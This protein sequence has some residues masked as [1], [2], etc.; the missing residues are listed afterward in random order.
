MIANVFGST[1]NEVHFGCKSLTHG[2]EELL[3]NQYGRNILIEH[4]LHKYLSINFREI[5]KPK[6]Y[7]DSEN[8]FAYFKDKLLGR[9]PSPL[10]ASNRLEITI[11]NWERSL[12]TVI[13]DN[14]LRKKILVSDL[15][16]I[17]V[18]G[19]IHDKNIH[20]VYLLALS[21]VIRDLGKE[22][23]W[24]NVTMQGENP[25]ILKKAI[26]DLKLPTRERFTF[27]YLQTQGLNAVNSFDTAVLAPFK[28]SSNQE[29]KESGKVLITGGVKGGVNLNTLIL[30]VK[31]LGKTPVYLPA[32]ISDI[33]NIEEM[34]DAGVEMIPLASIHYLDLP[35][36]IKKFDFV[37]SGRHHLNILSAI[38]GVPFIPLKSNSW[39]TEGIVDFFEINELFS[40]DLETSC[41]LL[42][43]DKKIFQEKMMAG[44]EKAK[45]LA[46]RN[47]L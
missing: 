32:A 38:G 15:N 23:K 17:N 33:E 31:K 24:V 3:Y 8:S 41:Q 19:T 39:K 30:T 5:Y 36:F 47:I 14:F 46:S 43:D 2:L 18:E 28:L 11:E 6:L 9:K 20:G 21:K 26:G 42:L 35:Q 34:K 1:K 44:I 10:L 45:T 27:E 25:E 37:I 13:N 7:A 16:I 12:K 4:T 22:V 40:N 29:Q